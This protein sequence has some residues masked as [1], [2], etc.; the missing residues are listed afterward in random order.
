ML[1]IGAYLSGTLGMFRSIALGLMAALM[2]G[3]LKGSSLM[4]VVSTAGLCVA[5]VPLGIAVLREPPTPGTRAFLRWF[6]FL[7]GFFAALFILGQLG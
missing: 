5:M 7:I 4:S 6:L 2:I 1:A 3:V